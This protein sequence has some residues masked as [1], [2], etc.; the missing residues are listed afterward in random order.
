M[1]MGK[2]PCYFLWVFSV[3]RDKDNIQWMKKNDMINWVIWK[4]FI[5]KFYEDKIPY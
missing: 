1:N 2:Q 5:L 3:Y 4:K